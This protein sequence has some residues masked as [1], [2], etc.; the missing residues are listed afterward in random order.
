[1]TAAALQ[2]N[3]TPTKQDY[4][5]YEEWHANSFFFWCEREGGGA[6]NT[7]FTVCSDE[8]ASDEYV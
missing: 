2:R 8:N 3:K 1:M 5:S 7:F 6:H 4:T